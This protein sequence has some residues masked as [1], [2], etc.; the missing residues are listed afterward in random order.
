M[1]KRASD[2][3]ERQ[4]MESRRVRRVEQRRVRRVL[5]V[6]ASI[7]ALG[8][9]VGMSLPR[10]TVAAV[11]VLVAAASSLAI[12]WARAEHRAPSHGLTSVVRFPAKVAA[13]ARADAPRPRI[14]RHR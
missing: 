2:Q 6:L 8:L 9:G 13:G 3:P 12:V 1:S 14:A 4:R 11:L 7:G 10:N 5:I